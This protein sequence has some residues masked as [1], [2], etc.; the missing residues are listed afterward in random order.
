[1]TLALARGADGLPLI[2]FADF[3]NLKVAHCGTATCG[4]A[5]TVT[6]LAMVGSMGGF[7]SSPSAPTA[8]P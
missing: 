8:S 7:P 4:R 6:T 3:T 5:T 1:M 2:A